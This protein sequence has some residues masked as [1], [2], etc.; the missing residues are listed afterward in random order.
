[1]A[2]DDED[3]KTERHPQ[4]PAGADM[5][6]AASHKVAPV[7]SW[8]LRV[9]DT[10]DNPDLLTPL[11]VTSPAGRNTALLTG[12]KPPCLEGFFDG[13]RS[14]PDAGE[15]HGRCRHVPESR[16]VVSP[17]RRATRD[18]PI[19]AVCEARL[20]NFRTV[21]PAADL[22]P[23]WIGLMESARA[24]AGFFTAA[25]AG[26]HHISPQLL[27]YRANAGWVRRE[28]RGVYH[29]TSAPPT[30]HDELIALWLWSGEEAVF[31]HVTALFLHGL[32]DALPARVHLSV[33]PSW[34]YARFAKPSHVTVH[35]GTLED[36]DRQWMGHIPVTT[37][38]RT[39][40]DCITA[41]VS[42][43]WVEQAITQARRC[44][45]ITPADAARLLRAQ[46]KAAA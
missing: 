26:A 27:R 20:Y 28:L 32:S 41:R 43:S 8:L 7:G 40:A 38:A 16:S 39:I 5:P 6:V 46:A 35:L 15:S 44:K 30:E 18:A 22:S 33:P 21:H 14:G 24:R 31:S 37:P 29:F 36:A 3:A 10:G 1:M 2:G 11:P 17:P 4:D 34:R 23:D 13:G 45:L 25:E 19:L 42:A 12:A 9:V